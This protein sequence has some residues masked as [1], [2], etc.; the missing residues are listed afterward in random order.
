MNESRLVFEIMQL[1]G[2]HGAVFRCNA[3]QFFTR[4]GQRVS[5][6]PKGFSDILFI[7]DDGRACFVEVKTPGGKTTPEQDK[8]I[9]RMQ[10]LGARAGIAHSALEAAQ[11]C[12][13]GENEYGL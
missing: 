9:E 10:K 12:G 5:G 2:L 11:I 13:I 8:F 4:S 7:G 3:G 6:L 1:L